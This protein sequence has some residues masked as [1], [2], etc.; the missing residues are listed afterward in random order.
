MTTVP[1]GN[2]MKTYLLGKV[3]TGVEARL[4]LQE[5]QDELDRVPELRAIA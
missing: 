3:K 2:D 1:E 5:V 4:F